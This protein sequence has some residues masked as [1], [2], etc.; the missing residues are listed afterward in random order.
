MNIEIHSISSVPEEVVS[1]VKKQVMEF[2]HEHHDIT[3]A[4]VSF[5]ETR[6]SSA[7]KVCEIKLNGPK[8]SVYTIGEAQTF[9]NAVNLAFRHIGTLAK[10]P[11]TKNEAGM[12][13]L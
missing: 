9:K 11:V 8:D 4:E 2:K 13:K 7:R 12:K 1:L 10:K 3:R 5:R 6:L